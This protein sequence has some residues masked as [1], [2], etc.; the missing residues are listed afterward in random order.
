MASGASALAVVPDTSEGC[1]RYV[2][3]IERLSFDSYYDLNHVLITLH[4]LTY[5]REKCYKNKYL[6]L[7][8]TRLSETGV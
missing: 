1:D 7:L 6:L 4:F 3:F 8:W 2:S 5:V